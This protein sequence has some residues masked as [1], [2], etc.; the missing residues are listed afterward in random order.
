MF[1]GLNVLEI[2]KLLMPLIILEFALRIFCIYLIIKNGVKNFSKLIW[3]V[4]VLIFTTIGPILFL[5]F[6]R[7]VYSND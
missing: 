6:G 1:E 7:R 2:I 5:L 3:I 4:I